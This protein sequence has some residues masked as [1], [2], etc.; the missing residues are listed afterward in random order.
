M[1]S[2]AGGARGAPRSSSHVVSGF[3]PARARSTRRYLALQ[4]SQLS[5]PTI[6]RAT[7]SDDE[8]RATCR[9]MAARVFGKRGKMYEP[10]R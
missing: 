1:M 6:Y 4:H 3:G 2:T 10:T 9:I 7:K 5:G 8:S